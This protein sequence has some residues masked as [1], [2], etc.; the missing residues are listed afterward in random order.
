MKAVIAAAQTGGHINP[1]LAIANKIRKEEPDSEI[2]F[3]GTDS[4]L[5]ADLVPREGYELKTVNCYGL[6]RSFKLSTIKHGI[7][8][9]HSVSEAKKILKEFNPD[10]VI[11]TGGFITW[12]V[13][14]AAQ[15]LHIP[16]LVHESNVLPGKATQ[17][18]SKKADKI[19]VGFEE[20]KDRLPKAKKVVFTGNPT[21][22]V[23]LDLTKQEVE[24]KKKENGY[25]VEKPLVLVF[26]GS[27][28]AKNINKSMIGL[29]KSIVNGDS[30]IPYQV[31]W[32]VGPKNFDGVKEELES[33]NIDVENIQDIK[34]LPYIYNMGEMMNIADMV[35][36]RSGAMT[37]TETEKIGVPAIFIPYPFAA[38]NHQ[39][40]NARTVEKQG[41]AK[42]L[43][44]DQITSTILNSM[45]CEMISDKENLKNM[46]KAIAA[47]SASNVED[48]IYNEVKDTV[49]QNIEK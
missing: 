36:C 7:Q 41:G 47:M 33:N 6:S 21:K 17:W 12:V 40:F 13:C 30:T 20:S 26:G 28:G 27:Q 35:V 4:G 38:E 15:K 46:A 39:E 45:I 9:L 11:G 22:V 49:L 16:Y 23:K 43:L 18:V 31:M 29:I 5:E 24:E 1:G 3:I 8:T 44:D 25:D 32:A 2:I 37:V 42:V 19:L 10:V 48:N 14:K 34:V